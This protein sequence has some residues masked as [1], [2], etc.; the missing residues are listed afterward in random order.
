MK[1]A[2]RMVGQAVVVLA[3]TL[4]LDYILL[5][6][7]FSSLKR[8]WADAA[9]AYAQAYIYTAYH[10]DLAPNAKSTRVWGNIAYPWRTDRYGFRTGTCAP[11]EAQKGWPA[12]FVIGDS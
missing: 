6:T 12:I 2:L 10:H 9:T 1:K 5:A 7:V 8:S 4:A 3:I 11:G